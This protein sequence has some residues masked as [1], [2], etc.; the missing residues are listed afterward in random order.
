[1]KSNILFFLMMLL[2][3]NPFCG[4]KEIKID[5]YFG[6]S[7]PGEIPQKF[8]PGIVSTEDNNEYGG[9]F[10]A[11]GTEFFFTRSSPSKIM[12]ARYED[13]RWTDPEPILE[14]NE[15]N[16]SQ[17]SISQDGSRL[18]FI[19]GN[20][21]AGVSEIGL[22]H[23]F[24][25]SERKAGIWGKPHQLTGIDLG[26]RRVC[27]SIAA[28]GNLYYSGNLHNPDDKDIFMIRFSDGEYSAPE[29]LGSS[30]NTETFEQHVHIASDESYIVFD[31]YRPGGSGK[32]DLY[33]CYKKSDGSWTN[34]R[35][36]GEAINT[37]D[38]DWFPRVTADGKY[39]LFARTAAGKIDL[40]WV[41]ANIIDDLK[42]G[43]LK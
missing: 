26:K 43:E 23:D 20:F 2:C 40:Y 36:L 5:N 15:Y 19:A 34:A 31:S 11:D 8:A 25:V 9:H 7:P 18:Y 1:M 10:S 13:G 24:Y 37:K 22:D 27:P 38:Y 4:K 42:P 6:Q 30:V 14:N 28:N 35:N 12:Y 29:N 32:S 21:K 3:F 39:L 16:C 17:T 41:S 33:I